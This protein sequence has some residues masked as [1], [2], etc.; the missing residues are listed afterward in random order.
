LNYEKT[1]PAGMNG[2]IL[3]MHIGAGPGRKDKFYNMLPELITYLK[4]KKYS[5]RR[6][7]ELLK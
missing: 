6:I 3:L 1:H 2:F 4:Q 7:D 5:L